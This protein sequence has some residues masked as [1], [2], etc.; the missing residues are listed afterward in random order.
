VKAV[1]SNQ[2]KREGN[3]LGPIFFSKFSFKDTSQVKRLDIRCHVL[4]RKLMF[5]TIKL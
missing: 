4:F 3:M 2:L 1:L 5:Q